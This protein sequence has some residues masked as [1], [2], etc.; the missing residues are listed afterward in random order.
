[1][2]ATCYRF[3]GV[4]GLEG[5]LLLEATLRLMERVAGQEGYCSEDLLLK[6][7]GWKEG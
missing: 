6:V 1:M 3:S 4:A 7:V 2:K 5:Y